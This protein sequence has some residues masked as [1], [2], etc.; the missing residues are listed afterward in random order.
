MNT[1]RERKLE[2]FAASCTKATTA[3]PLNSS[4]V[5]DVGDESIHH[6]ERTEVNSAQRTAEA[7]K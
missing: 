6:E 5:T 4:A 3:L 2:A 7:T 1:A